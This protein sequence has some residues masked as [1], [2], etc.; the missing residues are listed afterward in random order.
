MKLLRY[1]G[2]KSKL[3]SFLVNHLPKSKDIKGSYIEPFVGG[4]SVFFHVNPN[5]A[6]IS[7]LNPDLITLYKGIKLYPHKVWETFKLFP[8]GKAAYYSIR[9]ND[10]E[11]RP[12]YYKAARTLY[13]NRTCFKGMW[14]HNNSGNFNVGYGG[15]ER[16]WAITHENLIEISTIFRKA[17]I[18]NCDFEDVILGTSKNDFIFLDPP[19][20]P[21]DKDLH[22][23]HY[24]NGKFLFDEQIRL[25]ETLK[26]LPKSKHI[27][28]AMTNSSHKDI[29]KLYEGYKIE[30]IPFGT[31]DKLGIQTKSSNEVLITNY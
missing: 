21:G 15:E 29:L 9:D 6:L 10:T 23:L 28:W 25:A 11:G 22:E 7:D 24:S 8:K 5:R 4:G 2:G 20:K 31:G 17:E 16:R 14:R 27:H 30:K 18:N 13:L 3:L 19:Y 12:M 1:P 26:S